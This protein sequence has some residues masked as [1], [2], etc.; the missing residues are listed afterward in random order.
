VRERGDTVR[1]FTQRSV[2]LQRVRERLSKFPKPSQ[3]ILSLLAVVLIGYI[4]FLSGP[5]FAF[6]LFYLIPIAFISWVRGRLYGLVASV[7]AAAAWYVA[8]F[9]AQHMYANGLIGIWNTLVRFSFFMIVMLL[10][11][12]VNDLYRRFQGEARRDFL[13]GLFNIRYFYDV[14][15]AEMSRFRRYNQ[16]FSLAYIDL[17]NFKRVNDSLGHLQGNELLKTIAQTLSASVRASDTPARIGGDEFVVLFVN[18][19]ETQTGA[20]VEKIVRE[21]TAVISKNNWPVSLSI[22][23]VTY[24]KLPASV[25]EAIKLADDLMYEVKNKG[26]NK[27]LHRLY[28]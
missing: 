11:C 22:G 7:A 1:N 6:S 17:D 18:T 9:A 19:D 12:A 10:I 24:R 4:D 3:L 14:L 25:D 27:S 20:A 8:D 28:A 26:K 5:E 13:T 2:F 15:G 21:I 23:T 16:P